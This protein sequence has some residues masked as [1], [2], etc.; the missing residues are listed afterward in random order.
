MAAVRAAGAD[1]D[2]L[3]AFHDFDLAKAGFFQQFGQL[4]DR[5]FIDFHK[6]NTLSCCRKTRRSCLKKTGV[7]VKAAK[8]FR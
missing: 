2:G 8:E 1:A 7:K 4:A 5:G 3:L 6:K